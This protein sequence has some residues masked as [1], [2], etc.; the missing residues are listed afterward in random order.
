M[1]RKEHTIKYT[2]YSFNSS[3]KKFDSSRNERS[4]NKLMTPPP[5]LNK[6]TELHHQPVTDNRHPI[7]D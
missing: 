7:P 3:I 1:T 5:L 4:R 2:V 6:A